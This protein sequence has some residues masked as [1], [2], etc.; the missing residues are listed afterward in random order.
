LAPAKTPRDIVERLNAEFNKILRR[1][2]VKE[3]WAKQGAEMLIMSIAEFEQFLRQDIINQGRV[4]K[5]TGA[6]SE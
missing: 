2:D 5:M 1:P 4:I 6:K 3:A